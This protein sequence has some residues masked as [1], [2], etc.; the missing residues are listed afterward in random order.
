MA[1]NRYLPFGYMIRNGEIVINEQEAALVRTAFE[2]Y[3]T[4]ASYA[5]V[6]E[7]LQA[8]GIRY[9]SDT[10]LWNKHMVKRMLEN[11]RYAG[12]DDCPRIIEQTLFDSVASLRESRSIEIKRRKPA[13]PMKTLPDKLHNPVPN[14][15][16]TR[17]QNQITRE[18]S[19]P[20]SDPQRVR[21]MIFRLAQERFKACVEAQNQIE[22]NQAS[23]VAA[24]FD[25]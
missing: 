4:G 21:D 15:K 18:L 2:E 19:Q 5:A 17:M 14:M 25:I 8:T 13:G 7:T 20:I 9:H 22:S 3:M 12:T 11:S 6:A 16:I 24:R 1:K 23:G 10:P